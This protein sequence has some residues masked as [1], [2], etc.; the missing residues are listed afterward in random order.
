M[1]HLELLRQI[2]GNSVVL[3]CT[4]E[5]LSWLDKDDHRCGHA[6]L[7]VVNIVTRNVLVDFLHSNMLLLTAVPATLGNRQ[8]KAGCTA[9]PLVM[10]TEKSEPSMVVPTNLAAAPE[11]ASHV[12]Y[13]HRITDACM[14]R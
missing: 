11:Q 9:K 4:L 1:A 2:E 6:N 8:A 5:A 13:Q 14:H 7:L 12:G 10:A 3:L